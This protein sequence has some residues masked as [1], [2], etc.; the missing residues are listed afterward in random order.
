MEY[1]KKILKNKELI[2]KILF[3]LFVLVVFRVLSHVPIPGPSQ[4]NLKVFFD[5][6][7]TQNSILPFFDVFSGGGMSR[8]SVVLMGL[9]PYITASIMIQL[10]T[11]VIPKFEEMNK[12]TEDRKKLNQYT[13]ILTIPL[14]FI[15]G[16][17]MIKLLESIGSGAGVSLIGNIGIFQWFVMLL[18]I[19]AGTVFLM[20]LGELITEKGLGNGISI[21]I[22]AGIVAG[23]PQFVGQTIGK[24]FGGEQVDTQALINTGGIAVLAIAMVALIVFITEAKRKVP[25]SYAKKMRGSKLYGGIDTHLPL[26]LNMAGVIPIIFAGAFMNIPKVIGFLSNAKTEWIKKSADFIQTAFSTTTPAYAVFYFVLVFSFTFF[27]TFLY[28]KPKDVA[29]NLQKQGGFI[30]GI[31]P[32]TQTEKYLSYLIMRV[33]LWGAIF[34]S[35]I[36]VFPFVMQIFTNT[37]NFAIGGTGILIVVSVAIEVVNQLKAQIITRSY[38]EII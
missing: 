25:V 18:A 14:C 5:K 34:L 38:E 36:A 19:T 13:R 16:F 1:I 6:I 27:S 8:F 31:R 20:W 11:I 7:F 30:P 15:E 29:E 32:G 2:R 3:V 33:T 4:E 28:F 35:F 12:D 23:L 37:Q 21:L 24:V 22:F 9:G 17:G 26:K 10:L